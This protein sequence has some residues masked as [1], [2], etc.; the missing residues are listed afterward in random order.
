M[1]VFGSR[2]GRFSFRYLRA[3]KLKKKK[4]SLILFILFYLGL[5]SQSSRKRI[6]QEGLF[7]FASFR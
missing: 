6:K 7:L 2:Q 5:G 3:G 1:P 4:I